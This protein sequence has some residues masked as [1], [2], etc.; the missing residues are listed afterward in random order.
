V[1]DVEERQGADPRIA[2]ELCAL[3]LHDFRNILA[4]ADTSAHLCAASLDDKPFATRQLA[5]VREQLRRAQDLANRCMAVAKGEPLQRARVPFGDVC[6]EALSAVAARDGV[7]I[8][9]TP[10]TRS[11]ELT[12]D[13]SLFA[14]AL[15]N[16]IE[17][18]RDAIG[19][20]GTVSLSIERDGSSEIVRVH[21]DGPG[22]PPHLLFAGV[23]TKASGSGLGLL[24][25]RAIVVSHGG[26]IALEP[27]PRGTTFRITIPSAGPARRTP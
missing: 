13:T 22:I 17:N 7:S 20:R 12:C 21:D 9:V 3:V 10:D 6:D 1:T 23:T 8:V 16:L 2:G 19:A 14:R 4:V 5:R 26:D 11:V 27:S 15:A 18:A 25:V 24:V